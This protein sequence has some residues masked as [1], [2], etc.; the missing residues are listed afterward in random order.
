[1][2]RP[3]II[4][5]SLFISAPI[6][7]KPLKLGVTEAV[8]SVFPL[9][10][11]QAIQAFERI[12]VDVEI[13]VVPPARATR[14]LISGE[15]DGELMREPNYDKIAPGV[16]S[17]E[18]PLAIAHVKLFTLD[19]N[20]TDSSLLE[21]KSIAVLKAAPVLEKIAKEK[22]FNV[23]LIDD[24]EQGITILRAGRIDALMMPQE[25][26]T[27]ENQDLIAVDEVLLKVPFRMW[28]N[29]TY[30]HLIEPFSVSFN[31]VSGGN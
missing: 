18:Q 29:R 27:E 31:K 9:V 3:L 6:L 30:R 17:M 11:L 20:I 5:I 12:G 21:G 15:I 4:F 1:M 10:E 26:L 8:Y 23:N 14:M 19:A 24:F 7:S 2:L 13:I 28:L 22:G 25:W 16:V